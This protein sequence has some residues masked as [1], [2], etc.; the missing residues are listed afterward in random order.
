M[1]KNILIVAGYYIPGVK[2]GGPIQSIKNLVDNLS[3]EYNFYILANDRDLGDDIPYSITTDQWIANENSHIYYTNVNKLTIEKFKKITK[4]V[5]FDVIYLN[6]FFSFKLSIMPYLLWHYNFIEA[7]KM[8]IAPRGNFSEGALELKKIKKL[9]YI[10]TSNFFKLYKDVVWHA[11]AQTE[12]EDIKKFFS[13][14]AIITSV[15]NFTEDYR[16]IHYT[17]NEYKNRGQIKIIYLSRIHPKKNLTYALNILKSIT[18][19]VQFDIYGPIEDNVYWKECLEIIDDLPSNI[20][21]NYKGIAQHS[22]IINIFK[23]YHVFFF[24]TLGENFGHVISE[25]LI[26]GCPVIISDQT[27]WLNLK[28]TGMGMDISLTD[29]EKFIEALNYYIEMDEGEY[30]TESITAFE[31]AKK[32]SNNFSKIESYKKLFGY[33]EGASL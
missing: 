9:A 31:Q 12:K 1:K 11:T 30:H 13:K 16:A 8:V 7:Q 4:I 22:N 25:A 28:E 3:E 10:K 14:N 26:S 23:H 33:R 27:P 17:R 19:K 32:L 20:I 21:V 18:S 2:G 6:S 5:D 24:P 15:S 29:K